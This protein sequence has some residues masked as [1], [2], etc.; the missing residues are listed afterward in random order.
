[1]SNPSEAPP[2]TALSP[3]VVAQELERIAASVCFRKATR[4]V[5]L[6]RHVT[7]LTLEGR[8]GELKEYTLGVTI[9]ERPPSYDPRIDPIVRLEARRLRLKLSEYYQHEGANN[10]VIIGLPKGAYVP[11]FRLRQTPELPAAADSAPVSVPKRRF[12]PY[13]IAAAVIATVLI[14]GVFVAMRFLPNKAPASAVRPSVAVLGF[15]DLSAQPENSWIATALTEA[16]NVDLGSGHQFRM[17]PPDHVAQMRVELKLAPGNTYSAADLRQVRKN[18]DADYVVAG[19]YSSENGQVRLE[20]QLFDA[21]DGRQIRACEEKGGQA[22]MSDL[23][24]RCSAPIR[25]QLGSPS[26]ALDNDGRVP[27]L[28]PAAMESYA[29]GMERLRQSDALGARTFLEEAVSQAPASPLAHSA[30]AAAW[31][32]LG[33]DAKAQQEGS[34][35]FDRTSGLGRLEQL[36]IE[37]RYRTMAHDWARAIQIYQAIFTLLPDDLESGLLLA[38]VQ[39]HGGDAQNALR[40]VAALRKLPAPLGDDPRVDLAEAQAAGAMSDFERTRKAAH[41]AAEKALKK[42]ARLQYARAR[43][44]ESGAM[45]NLA[46][47]G[48]TEVR[49]EARRICTELGDR[50][51]VAASLRIEANSV[52]ALGDL[53]TARRLYEEVLETANE[54]GNSLEKLNALNGLGYTS[55]MQGDLRTAEKE[56]RAALETAAELGSTKTSSIELDLAEVLA[57]RGRIADA[58]ALITHAL[59]IARAAGEKEGIAAGLAA[60]A[61]TLA[62]KGNFSEAQTKYNESIALL[63]E[64]SEPYQI[65]LTLLALADTFV[66]QGKLEAARK[67]DEEAQALSGH[68]PGGFADPEI[69]MAFA[70]VN[71]AGRHFNEAETSARAALNGFTRSGREGD[72]MLAAGILARALVA[73]GKIQQA[74]EAIIQAPSLDENDLPVWV[75]LEFQIAKSDCLAHSGKSAEAAKMMDTAA[76]QMQRLGLLALEKEALTAKQSFR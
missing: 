47:P 64:V 58:Q 70:R 10:P 20:V 49:A 51:C 18:L 62:L 27:P 24:E 29:R 34:L 67:I 66:E 2:V 69:N 3:T 55:K 38:S 7:T 65:C 53:S 68:F 41:T 23:V 9:F 5:L 36:E 19:S 59:E 63:R 16:M 14:A 42:G 44:L 32:M 31:S 8:A 17:V 33:Q 76:A 4:C 35:A 30:L 40:T 71:L 75:P 72:R 26:R 54:I 6:L 48:F 73:E 37:G 13:S 74:S 46:L 60:W 1:L 56:Y 15:R 57:S 43:L 39:T 61:Q 12:P 28:D 45:Q 25:S 52:A 22:E 50:A 11:D 21:H